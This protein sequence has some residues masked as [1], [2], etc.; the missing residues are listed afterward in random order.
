MSIDIDVAAIARSARQLCFWY[1][2]KAYRSG[3]QGYEENMDS[4]GVYP[5]SQIVRGRL[6]VRA[7]SAIRADGPPSAQERALQFDG[8]SYIDR[9]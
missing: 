4:V 3:K 6:F 7:Q 8:S 5:R 9:Y 1:G 2:R